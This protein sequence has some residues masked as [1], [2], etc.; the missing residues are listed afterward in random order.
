MTTP[1]QL[2]P[3]NEMPSALTI[4]P[5]VVGSTLAGAISL[6]IGWLYTKAHVDC[7]PEVLAA[8]TLILATIGGYLTK[9]LPSETT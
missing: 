9:P 2:L 6:L 3:N 4:H 1:N 7:P 5:K 8:Q